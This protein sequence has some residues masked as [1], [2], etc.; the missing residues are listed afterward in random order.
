MDLVVPDAFF[1]AFLELADLEGVFAMMKE[2]KKVVWR[3]KEGQG[4]LARVEL[5]EDCDCGGFGRREKAIIR[6]NHWIATT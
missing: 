5:D 4:G 1:G 2:E 3:V 6:R